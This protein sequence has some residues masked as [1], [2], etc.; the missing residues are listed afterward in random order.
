MTSDNIINWILA[1][2]QPWKSRQSWRP[3][4][5]ITYV[6]KATYTASAFIQYLLLDTQR[7]FSY[8]DVKNSLWR[9]IDTNMGQF[10]SCKVFECNSQNLPYKLTLFLLLFSLLLWENSSNYSYFPWWEMLARHS[11]TTYMLQNYLGIRTSMCLSVCLL[12]LCRL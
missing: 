1:N 4:K 11:A 10:K 5:L 7:Q 2:L 6:I 12:I 3:S 8:L 9:N